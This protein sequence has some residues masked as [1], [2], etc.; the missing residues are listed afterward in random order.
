MS[1]TWHLHHFEFLVSCFD[2]R[3]SKL[4][5]VHKDGEIL[6]ITACIPYQDILELL[7]DRKQSFRSQKN[8]FKPQNNE[9]VPG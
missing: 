6:L 5:D 3:L 4:P 8:A 1:H 7:F 2:L 9:L